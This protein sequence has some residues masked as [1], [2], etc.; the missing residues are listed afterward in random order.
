ML[1]IIWQDQLEKLTF[2]CWQFRRRCC[3]LYQNLRC[4]DPSKRRETL[5]EIVEPEV[6]GLLFPE[7]A[8]NG[9]Y[10]WLRLMNPSS[11]FMVSWPRLRIQMASLTL[12]LFKLRFLGKVNLLLLAQLLPVKFPAV[13]MDHHNASF[14]KADSIVGETVN[15]K[16]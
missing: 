5:P 9:S 11:L 16:M 12:L 14:D 15:R 13:W 8:N 3:R 1:M 2:F 6:T 4:D 7:I 10:T